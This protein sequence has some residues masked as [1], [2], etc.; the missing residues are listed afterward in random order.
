M[1]AFGEAGKAPSVPGPLIRVRA[2]TVL[3]ID[4]RNAAGR[5]LWLRG[6]HDHPIAP[7]EGE[8]IEA[9]SVREF[10]FTATTP[11]TY[12][13]GATLSAVRPGGT[14]ATSA[15]EGALL[16]GAFIVDS[17]GA[18]AEPRDRVL[19]LTRWA[20]RN[21]AD[22]LGVALYALAAVNGKSWPH[23]ERLSY[24]VGDTVRWR[25]INGA[26]AP[27]P[28]HLHGFYFNVNA[29]GTITGDTVLAN[30]RTVV[31]E[32]LT[33]AQTMQMS[34]V[35]DRPGNWLFHCHLLVHMAGSQHLDRL[36]D[37]ASIALGVQLPVSASSQTSVPA[38]HLAHATRVNHAMEGMAGLIVGIQVSPAR[39][40]RTSRERS[41]APRRMLRVFAN[42]KPATSG[43]APRYGF[44]LQEGDKEPARDSVRLP[45]SPLILR[46]GEPVQITVFNR[47]TSPLSVH[48][49]GLEVDSYF[50]GVGDWSGSTGSIAPPITPGDSFVVRLTPPRAGTF[51][52]HV[53]G[54]EGRE[55][56]YGLYAPLIVLD[57]PATLDTVTDK[58]I[59]VSDGG[60]RREDGVLVNGSAAPRLTLTAG[61]AHRL[62]LIGITSNLAPTVTLVQGTDTLAWRLLA[63]DGAEL[64][65]PPEPLTRAR[66]VVG[67]GTIADVELT[68][69]K[70]G[71]LTMLVRIGPPPG[72]D[73]SLAARF[74]RTMSVPIAVLG[75][76]Q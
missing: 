61:R 47:L 8:R 5:P 39:G 20:V 3:R 37:S 58:V 22:T 18:S 55:L 56:A 74:A 54:E 73:P 26:A 67:P 41:A 69:A 59:V 1:L 45:G 53:H 16:V 70:P 25:V 19:V 52:Y 48:W 64:T 31:T 46:R 30:P 75:E 60:A 10:R 32:G 28:M 71:E 2:G 13:Y 36:P 23:T 57:G 4:V 51:M 66:R 6:F 50:D 44:V 14:I 43:G 65:G 76:R 72:V 63:L 21:P 29:K 34:W 62:R 68:P 17:A 24:T 35:P 38:A 49:H 40:T 33:A 42:E 9:D 11:G 15:S 7:T 27:H 12:A